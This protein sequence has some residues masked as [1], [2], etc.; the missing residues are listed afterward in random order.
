[1]QEWCI[2]SFVIT[3]DYGGSACNCPYSRNLEAEASQYV[4]TR[5][6]ALGHVCPY[7]CCL[8]GRAPVQEQRVAGSR[9]VA[10]SRVLGIEPVSEHEVPRLTR[11]EIDPPN[12]RV[13]EPHAE[14]CVVTALARQFVGDRSK[15]YGVELR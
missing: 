12:E 15:R 4:L 9:G 5:G 6:V 1:M 3:P 2:S 7:I 13:G 10:V 14:G 11:Y 8:K